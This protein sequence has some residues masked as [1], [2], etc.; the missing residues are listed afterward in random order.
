VE[1][2]GSFGK[3]VS[4]FQLPNRPLY[5]VG[6]FGN[7]FPPHYLAELGKVFLYHL[8]DGVY[9]IR[10]LLLRLHESTV[11]LF[12]LSESFAAKQSTQNK[13]PMDWVSFFFHCSSVLFGRV[14]RTIRFASRL[15]CST[16][17]GARLSIQ[18]LWL[19]HFSLFEHFQPY[20]IMLSHE[21]P[22]GLL[23]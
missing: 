8:K 17:E 14:C 6:G 13:V 10:R 18:I 16:H 23:N 1:G 15:A 19:A 22:Y 21:R 11:A 20:Q 2:C 5:R 12:R 4:I 3:L 9:S 7:T